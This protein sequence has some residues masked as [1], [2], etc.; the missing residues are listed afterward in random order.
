MLPMHVL[1]YHAGSSIAPDYCSWNATL[2]MVIL[3]VLVHS[4]AML[5]MQV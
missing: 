4:L 3:Y 2:S 1:P 5:D